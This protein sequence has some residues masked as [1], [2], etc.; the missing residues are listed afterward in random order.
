[1]I[2]KRSYTIQ[3]DRLRCVSLQ[4]S[5]TLTAVLCTR[6]SVQSA[7]TDEVSNIVVMIVFNGRGG[8]L[9]K[10]DNGTA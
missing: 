1:M 3:Q 7:E 5:F 6:Q 2:N 10:I 4:H 8:G 9:L